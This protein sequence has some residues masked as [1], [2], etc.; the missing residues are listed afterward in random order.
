MSIF[1]IFKQIEKEKQPQ[2]PIEYIIAGLGNPGVKYE[3]TRHNCG[4]MSAEVLAE[5]HKTEIKRLKFKSLTAEIAVGDK[6]CLLMKPTT[7]MNNS[8]EAV[9]EAA[10]FY[11]IPP[12]KITVIYDDI[13]LDV[14]R[15]RIR[16]KGSDGGHNGM[17][18]IILHLNSDNFPRIRVGVGK[19]PHPDYDLADWVLSRFTKEEGERLEPALSN[20]AKAA[21]LIVQ[22]RINEAMNLYNRG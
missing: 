16:Q 8:G 4:F 1:D 9:E 14:G 21:E 15:L 10:S 2:A 18:S 12:E 13:N 7:F 5:A 6:R 22:G 17:K 19:K 3:D 11:K 20:A